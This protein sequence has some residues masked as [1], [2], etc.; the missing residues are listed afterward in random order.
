MKK[1]SS[2][3][4]LAN[5]SSVD[6]SG[7]AKGVSVAPVTYPSKL[8]VLPASIATLGIDSVNDP[9]SVGLEK[10][11]ISEEGEKSTT[12]AA[13]EDHKTSPS[14]RAV[15]LLE[16]PLVNPAGREKVTSSVNWPR[17]NEEVSPRLNEPKSKVVF[18]DVVV[19][20]LVPENV[21]PPEPKSPMPLKL[22][23]VLPS[24]V[25]LSAFACPQ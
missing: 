15:K 12:N 22:P 3:S 24:S 11:K 7:V 19:S 5:S 2:A 17:Y 14:S 10:E 6:G 13:P 1:K 21:R 9:E 20:K 16:L 25:R 18:P 23:V 8:T 4:P